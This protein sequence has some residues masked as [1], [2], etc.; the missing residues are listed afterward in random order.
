MA[1]G[2]ELI[3]IRDNQRKMRDLYGKVQWEGDLDAMRRAE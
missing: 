1:G 2:R 3:R